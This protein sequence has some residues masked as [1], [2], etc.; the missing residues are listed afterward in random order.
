MAFAAVLTGIWT[1][2]DFR[3]DGIEQ[4]HIFATVHDAVGPL[5]VDHADPGE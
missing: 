5:L 4:H 2:A 1:A 3:A